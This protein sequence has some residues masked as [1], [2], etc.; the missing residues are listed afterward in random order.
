L[1]QLGSSVADQNASM[2]VQL[3]AKYGVSHV[4]NA[5]LSAVPLYLAE[6]NA[7]VFSGMPPYDLWTRPAQ[8]RPAR[9]AAG[10]G[11]RR[12]AN[13]SSEPT[14]GLR[15]AQSVSNNAARRSVNNTSPRRGRSWSGARVDSLKTIGAITRA[16]AGV[17]KTSTTG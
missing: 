6:V 2:L 1:T 3:L 17:I 13:P 16:P 14:A 8:R 10:P 9:G 12:A 7:V 15:G 11:R 4:G 5:G